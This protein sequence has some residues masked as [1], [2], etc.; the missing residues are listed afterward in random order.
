MRGGEDS[1]QRRVDG[2]DPNFLRMPEEM[3]GMERYAR[4]RRWWEASSQ[5]FAHAIT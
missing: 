5:E 4:Q 3:G 1:V 2:G